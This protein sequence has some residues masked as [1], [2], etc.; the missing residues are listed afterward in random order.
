VGAVVEGVVR[1]VEKGALAGID[2]GVEVESR[3]WTSHFMARTDAEGRYRLAGV[4]PGV[5]GVT[6]R[7]QAIGYHP[8]PRAQLVVGEE[9][10]VE[11]DLVLGRVLVEG[12]VRDGA[13]GQALPE[14]RVDVYPG[15]A[16]T[17]TDGAGLFRLIDLPPG[18]VNLSFTKDGYG[19]A[20]RRDVEIADGRVAR[21]DVDLEPAAV[22]V[23]RLRDSEGDPVTGQFQLGLEPEGGKGG[24]TR[25]VTRTTDGGGTARYERIE[26]G[27]YVVHVEM[28]GWEADDVKAVVASGETRVEVVCRPK[29]DA[30]PPTLRGVVRDARTREPL[31]GVRVEAQAP[32]MG[33]AVTNARGEYAL[34]PYR[35]SPARLVVSRDGYGIVFFR[36]VE[37]KPDETTTFDVD[38]M[39]AAVVHFWV[40]DAHGDPVVGSLVL[41][42]SPKKGT[43]GTSLGTGIRAD[44]DGH[45]V[46]EK[47]VPG[48]YTLGIHS[49]QH[50]R[51]EVETSVRIGENTVRIRLE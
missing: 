45:A 8:R 13:T 50:G 31:A 44:A 11:R 33:T 43:E 32:P 27:T 14:V 15:F 23:V 19:P 41:V 22:L 40:T 26:P 34:G 9:T 17:T 42:V 25:Y 5:H 38:L 39:P 28:R 48:E 35:G 30:E 16:Q 3:G 47:I 1:H 29:A 7:G 12:R 2:V 46:Y 4:P 49:E 37:V 18:T 21:V 20:S 10:R 6:L 51:G 24:G 36:G